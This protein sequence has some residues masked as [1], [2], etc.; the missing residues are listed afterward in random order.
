[1]ISLH[2]AKAEVKIEG[3]LHMEIAN[4]METTQTSEKKTFINKENLRNLFFS[5]IRVLISVVLLSI[6]LF[7]TKTPYM[8]QSPGSCNNTSLFVFTGNSGQEDNPDQGGFYL[9]TVIYERANV[10]FFIMGIMD[11]NSELIPIEVKEDKDDKHRNNIMHQQMENSK[12]KAKIAAFSAMGFDVKA[13]KG[14]VEIIGLASWSKGIDFLQQGDIILEIDGIKIESDEHLIDEIKDKSPNSSVNLTILR[15][16]GESEEIIHGE[17]PLTLNQNQ[18]KIG[19]HVMSQYKD[20]ELPIPVNI[21]SGNV[22]GSSAGLMFSLEIIRQVSGINITGGKKI[23]GTGSIDEEGKVHTVEGI[24]FKVIAAEDKNCE[25]FFCPEKNYH[26]AAAQAKSI[27]VIPVKDLEDALKQLKKIN[28]HI[29]YDG[30]NKQN[31]S[32]NN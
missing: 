30:I 29:D 4:K 27:K 24:K 12:D 15:K 20:I 1:M 5:S 2:Q 28:P 14:P 32:K 21:D 26:E 17:V 6:V 7:F 8:F 22:V 18:W 11:K 25:Y 23:A 19:I 9:T 31:I 3:T 10:L 16:S 13:K